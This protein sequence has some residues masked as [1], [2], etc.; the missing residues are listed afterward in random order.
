MM[1]LMSQEALRLGAER[2]REV[3]LE[4]MR[5]ARV[6]EGLRHATGVAIVANGERVSGE[7]SSGNKSLRPA[8]DCT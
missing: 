5:D 7:V 8:A 3:A 4:T 6:A 1:E 2:R